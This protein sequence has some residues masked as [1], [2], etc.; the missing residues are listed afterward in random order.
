MIIQFNIICL[1]GLC[2]G[3]DDGE[4]DPPTGIGFFVSESNAMKI[5]KVKH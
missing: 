1:I 2:V 5:Y 3:S 4:T